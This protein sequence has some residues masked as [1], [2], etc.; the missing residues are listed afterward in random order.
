MLEDLRYQSEHWGWNKVRHGALPLSVVVGRQVLGSFQLSSSA[1]RQWHLGL[2]RRRPLGS[3]S[4]LCRKIICGIV[5]KK[6]FQMSSYHYCILDD[7]IQD[8]WLFDPGSTDSEKI[9]SG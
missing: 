9:L 4:I 7:P 8:H 2:L 6:V 1:L 5:E 3:K